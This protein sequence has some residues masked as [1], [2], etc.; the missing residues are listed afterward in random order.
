MAADPLDSYDRKILRHLTTDGRMTWKDLASAIGLSL[1]PTIRR[2]R[3]L[4]DGGYITG[5]AARLDEGLLIG[6]MSVFVS[7]TLERQIREALEIFEE[8]VATLSEVMSGFLM[9]GG[10]DYLLQFV[11]PRTITEHTVRRGFAPPTE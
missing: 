6:R 5:Y 2:V 1:T 9:S 3:N 10:A 4:E 7:V 11:L 8:R